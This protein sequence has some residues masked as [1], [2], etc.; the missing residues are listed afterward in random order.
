MFGN[1]ERI[2]DYAGYFEE[3]DGPEGGPEGGKDGTFDNLRF[4]VAPS[5]RLEDCLERG[6]EV[7]ESIHF[8]YNKK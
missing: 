4:D 1:T 6:S 5:V 3:A 2:V 8:L 7:E